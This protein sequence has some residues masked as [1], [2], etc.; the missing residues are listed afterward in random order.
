M[1]Y[2]HLWY[3]SLCFSVSGICIPS[4]KSLADRLLLAPE[5]FIPSTK[6]M[7]PKSLRHTVSP[8]VQDASHQKWECPISVPLLHYG[9]GQRHRASIQSVGIVF[10]SYSTYTCE[11]A[12]GL[13]H[14]E[15]SL[16]SSITIGAPQLAQLDWTRSCLLSGSH[17]G[18]RG[19]GHWV[20]CSGLGLG[21][22]MDWAWAC[23]CNVTSY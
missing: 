19:K 3:S 11:K 9:R 6:P 5:I 13:L 8:T 7:I 2:S 20:V 22:G 17:V 14:L 12:Q 4:C 1:F 15:F 21:S 16:G 18:L 10:A 23:L